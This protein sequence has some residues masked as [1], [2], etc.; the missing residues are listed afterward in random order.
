MVQSVPPLLCPDAGPVLIS[1]ICPET[2]SITNNEIEKVQ[3]FLDIIDI[4]I[5]DLVVF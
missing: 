5:I 1:D 3:K 4:H 2:V